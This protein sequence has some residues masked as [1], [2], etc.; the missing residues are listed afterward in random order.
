MLDL[1][2]VYDKLEQFETADEIACFLVQ[3][4]VKA[5]PSNGVQC[6]LAKW[7]KQVTESEL[8]VH[9]ASSHSVV[10][11]EDAVGPVRKEK[12]ILWKREHTQPMQEFI[13]KFDQGAYPDLISSDWMP[14][15]HGCGGALKAGNYQFVYSG[16]DVY[17][18]ESYA[19]PYTS[20]HAHTYDGITMHAEASAS[21]YTIKHFSNS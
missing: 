1:D 15:D 8:A 10:Y 11:R 4:Q 21:N 12:A 16:K 2:V 17:A 6:A 19:Q 7:V 18:T 9:V 14:H 13:A 20:Y 3:E 5:L